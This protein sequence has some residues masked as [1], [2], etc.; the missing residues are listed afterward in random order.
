MRDKEIAFH[1]ADKSKMSS[2]ALAAADAMDLSHGSVNSFTDLY[3]SYDLYKLLDVYV[4]EPEKRLEIHRI[5]GVSTK[6]ANGALTLHHGKLGIEL[7]TV[8]KF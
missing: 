2:A 4:N 6:P 1:S 8:F 5:I 7:G 3:K